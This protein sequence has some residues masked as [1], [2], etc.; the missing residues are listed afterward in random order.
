MP[1]LSRPGGEVERLETHGEHALA[2]KLL[3]SEGFRQNVSLVAGRDNGFHGDGTRGVGADE[4]SG[5]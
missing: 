4:T 1:T 5:T 3:A 2:F